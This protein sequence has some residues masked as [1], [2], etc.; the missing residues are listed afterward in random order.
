MCHELVGPVEILAKA[1][2]RTLDVITV[3]TADPSDCAVFLKSLINHCEVAV[4][5]AGSL[6][7]A[8][9]VS[10]SSFGLVIDSE[11][12]V[13][14]SGVVNNLQHLESLLETLSIRDGVLQIAGENGHRDGQLEDGRVRVAERR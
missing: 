10:G 14:Q 1:E 6:K 8:L 13:G 5:K 9:R 3:C 4:D 11:G 2:R 12:R 7:S